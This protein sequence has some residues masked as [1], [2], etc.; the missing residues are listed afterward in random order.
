MLVV[1]AG[2][3]EGGEILEVYVF[4]YPTQLFVGQVA[5]SL[6]TMVSVI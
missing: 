6:N 1:V 2:P 4:P 5:I 3:S